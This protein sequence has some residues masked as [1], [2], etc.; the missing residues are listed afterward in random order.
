MWWAK[1]VFVVA[2]DHPARRGERD[3]VADAG[4]DVLQ[5]AARTRVVEHFV[6]GD[7]WDVECV[8]ARADPDF[9]R[10]VVGAAMA[11]QGNVEAIAKRGLEGPDQIGRRIDLVAEQVAPQRDRALRVLADLGPRHERI[12]FV[13]AAPTEC[14]EPR[15]VRPT[16][17]IHREQHDAR[18]IRVARDLD[19]GRR[20]LAIAEHGLPRL[21]ALRATAPTGRGNRRGQ[22]I[23]IDT[24]PWTAPD[25]ADLA[26][27]ANAG[28]RDRREREL[29]CGRR[30][31]ELHAADQLDAELFGFLVRADQAV[32]TI[33][34]GDRYRSQ[35]ETMRFFDQL[36]GV[37]GAFEEREVRLAPQRRIHTVQT[38]SYW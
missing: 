7:E 25:L 36:F 19:I 12:A 32:H 30:D 18:G 38:F 33:A 27:Q 1:I 22:I 4:E 24:P 5:R 2:A 11:R 21:R 34:I 23:G 35:A 14:R 26:V 20:A 29:C 28:P 37:A 9:S 6:R 31:R 8:R 13:T 10:Y 15:E 16:R 3:L 17:A